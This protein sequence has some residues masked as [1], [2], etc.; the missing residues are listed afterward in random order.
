LADVEG[1]VFIDQISADVDKRTGYILAGGKNLTE[2]NIVLVLDKPD[3]NVANVI[4]NRLNERFGRD[5]ARAVSSGR[6]ELKIPSNYKE[7]RK[8]FISMVRAMYLEETP[9]VTLKRINYYTEE[10]ARKPKKE[11]NEIALE[12]IGNKSLIELA[13]LLKESDE[14]VRLRAARCILNVGS[15]ASLPVLRQIALDKESAYRLEALEAI[16]TAVR[17]DEAASIARRLLNDDDF[18]ISLAAYEQLRK[19]DDVSIT[20]EAIDRSFYLEQVVRSEQK[21]VFAFRSGQ[22][23]V[24][25][26]GAP[27]YCNREIF[28]KSPDGQVTIDAPANSWKVTIIRTHPTRPGVIVRVESS[29]D[30]SDIIRKLC[31][32]PA[33]EGDKSRGGLGVSYADMIALLQQMCDKGAINAEFRVGPMPKIGFNVKK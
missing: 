4:R 17:T 28:I 25:L 9:E 19:L 29:F 20:R 10:L 1:P 30:L 11:D 21:G 31:M 7:D 2:Q 6:I 5:I 26:F 23:R 16:I 33:I 14:H 18:D 3:F 8:R 24:V 13:G 12:A 15:N 27:I 32:E 22:P